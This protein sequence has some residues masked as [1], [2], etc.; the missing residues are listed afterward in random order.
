MALGYTFV[1]FEA[2]EAA[3][4]QLQTTKENLGKQLKTI[5]GV[6]DNSVDNP[7]IIYSEDARVLKEQFEDMYS[8]WAVKFDNYV[9]EYID[10]FKKAEQTYK[11]RGETGSREAQQLNSFID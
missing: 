11:Q 10:F 2:L 9:Q 1:D 3:I 7:E 5:K 6:V 4:K 8:R